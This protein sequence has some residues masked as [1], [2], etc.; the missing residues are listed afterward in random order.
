MSLHHVGIVYGS[1]PNSSTI[2]R[3]G[4]AIRYIAT[5]V[6]QHGGRTT[7]TLARGVDDYGHFDLETRPDTLNGAAARANR[8][9]AIE[10]Q[11]KVL[12]AGAEQR[13]GA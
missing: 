12:Y 3:I 5:H 11:H 8:Q 9:R 2:P 6:R 4:F 1:D 10:Q 7:A 13:A